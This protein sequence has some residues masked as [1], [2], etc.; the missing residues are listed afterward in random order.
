MN[1]TE[2]YSKM[3]RELQEQLQNQYI[4]NKEVIN[5]NNEL[6]KLLGILNIP[7]SQGGNHD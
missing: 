2:I 7:M 3:I 4:R 6:N 5:E 1:E